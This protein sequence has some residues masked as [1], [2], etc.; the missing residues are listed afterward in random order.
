MS[1]NLN[2]IRSELSNSDGGLGATQVNESNISWLFLQEIFTLEESVFEGNGG[3]F[4]N[5]LRALESSNLGSVE[6]SLSLNV[7]GIRGAG[8]DNFVHVE[9]GSSVEFLQLNKIET[10]NLLNTH[11]VV[12]SHLFNLE[13]DF[14]SL[15]VLSNLL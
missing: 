3:T 12:F 4:V 11:F 10:E 14:V 8:K 1:D 5:H 7:G 9:A 13:R 15:S 2:L 6:E